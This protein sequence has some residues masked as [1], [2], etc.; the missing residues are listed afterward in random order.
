MTLTAG[1]LQ[2]TED[3]NILMEALEDDEHLGGFLTFPLPNKENGFDIE[4][5]AVRGDRV[6]LGLRGPVLGRWAV[7]LEIEVFEQEPGT[8]GLREIGSG[9]RRYKKHFVDLNGMGVRELCLQNDDLIILAG[10]TMDL[11][12]AMEVF[13]LHNALDIED[14]SL[15]EQEEGKL[16]MLFDLPFT[17]GSDHAEGLALYSYF[18]GVD[19]LLVVYDS[20]D[21][22]RVF[23]P[24]SVFAD[25]FLL[26]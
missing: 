11:E 5:I 2:A 9:G 1:R 10:P 22:A 16:D 7:L 24:E 15:T 13:R 4:G 23:T 20:P 25:V 8:L 17:I 26:R 12:G 3:W 21:P 14:D 19:G 18:N 6:F